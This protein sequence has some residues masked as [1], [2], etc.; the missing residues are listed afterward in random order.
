MR[1]TYSLTNTDDKIESMIENVCRE[2]SMLI[3][4]AS[5][6]RESATEVKTHTLTLNIKYKQ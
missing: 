2:N 3:V 4:L 5:L 1:K 6:C